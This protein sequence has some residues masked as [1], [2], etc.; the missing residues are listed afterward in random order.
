MATTME[1]V[2][3]VMVNCDGSTDSFGRCVKCGQAVSW[4]TGAHSR[5]VSVVIPEAGR[6]LVIVTAAELAA[7][8]EVAKAARVHVTAID[9]GF[10]S[11]VRPDVAR[12]RVM[13]ALAKLDAVR[14]SK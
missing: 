7:L 13:R 4:T 5:T 6:P 9:E 3:Q 12:V 1:T 14:G 2:G 8:H 11:D 10:A